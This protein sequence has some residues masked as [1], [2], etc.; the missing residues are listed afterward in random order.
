MSTIVKELLEFSIIFFVFSIFISMLII[1]NT[2]ENN[3]GINGK[4]SQ[5]LLED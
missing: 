1:A 3:L 5:S 4:S 2:L